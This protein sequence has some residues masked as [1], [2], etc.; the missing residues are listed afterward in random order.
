VSALVTGNGNALRVFFNSRF[1][2]F[3]DA[4]VMP[5]VNDLGSLLLEDPAHN[6]D[7]RVVP[8][9]E[10]GRGYD[11]D[12]GM[13]CLGHLFLASDGC[14]GKINKKRMSVSF[15]K[16]QKCKGLPTFVLCSIGL[17]Q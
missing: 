8:V 7:S 13:W 14:G 4:A 10:T 2:N 9:K 12:G 5:Q 1:Y 11:A 16:R 17:M 15:Q 6:I 3:L